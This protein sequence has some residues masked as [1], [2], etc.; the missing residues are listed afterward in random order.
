[1]VL[2]D[3]PDHDPPVAVLDFLVP[4]DVFPVVVATGQM[5]V[6]VI[7]GRDLDVLPAHIQMG[8]RPAPFVAHRDLRLGARKA[9]ADQQQAQP[10]FLGGLGTAVDEVQ[11]GSCGLH[12]TAAPIA[13][14][15]RLDV[16]H[17]QIGGLYQG[18]DG[19]DGG[20]QWKS[21]GQV[22][23]R[24]LRCGHA[25][26]LDDADL[27]GLDALFP[28]LQPR[29]TAA[30][31]VDDRGGKIRVDPLGAMEGRSRVAGQHAAA[32]RAQPQRFCTQLRGQFHTLR[33]VHVFM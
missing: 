6:A 19:R 5:V 20:V 31:G 22:E 12:A 23:R 7:L 28:D 16:G 24:S 8:F 15:Q 4:E 29:G 18:V 33:H 9:G 25:H 17:L 11:S 2:G 1:M 3:D 13:L 14:D 21:T 27:V 26:A 10:G 30:V 32:A